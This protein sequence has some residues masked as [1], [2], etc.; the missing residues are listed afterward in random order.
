MA[1]STYHCIL[2]RLRAG[3][4]TK[5]LGCHSSGHRRRRRRLLLLLP[6]RCSGP[7]HEPSTPRQTPI[8]RS[9]DGRRHRMQT[10]AEHTHDARGERRARDRRSKAESHDETDWTG[11]AYTRSTAC[12]RVD[13]S[14]G[15][16]LRCIKVREILGLPPGPRH[17][18]RDVWTFEW[19]T[20]PGSPPPLLQGQMRG[21][22]ATGFHS[23]CPQ[24]WTRRVAI[25]YATGPSCLL[26]AIEP[27]TPALYT[28]TV[29]DSLTFHRS[30]LVA[31]WWMY[32][33][34]G[35]ISQT[36]TG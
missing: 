7:R 27:R 20:R 29:R 14:G 35:S 23:T 30:S 6:S 34:R 2:W 9:Q 26:A 22:R 19:S 12:G 32:L 3:A 33:H 13:A 18:H 28:R 25:G 36:L 8:A 31:G 1:P 17:Q 21:G 4:A 10:H 11:R 5:D 15:V 24:T 16:F